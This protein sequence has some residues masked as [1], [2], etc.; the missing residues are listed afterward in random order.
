MIAIGG[1]IVSMLVTEVLNIPDI[2]RVLDCSL[3][4]DLIWLM[5]DPQV[6]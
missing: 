5:V 3:E 2:R 1:V 4:L 6:S